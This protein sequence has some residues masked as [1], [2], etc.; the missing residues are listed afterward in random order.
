[1]PKTRRSTSASTDGHASTRDSRDRL[2]R[3]SSRALAPL[4]GVLVIALTVGLA[5]ATSGAIFVAGDVGDVTDDTP[6]RAS[7]SLSVTDD[8]LSFTHRG[9]DTLDVTRVELVVAVDGEPLASQPPVPFFSARG[10]DSGPRGPFNAASDPQW[11]AG[12]TATLS[13]AGTN[14]PTLSTGS[15]VTVDVYVGDRLLAELSAR[16]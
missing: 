4:T 7:L 16:A 11:T 2:A 5:A 13:L 6:R 1:M 12:E 14:Q 9:G 15:L 3:R 8:V 10:F